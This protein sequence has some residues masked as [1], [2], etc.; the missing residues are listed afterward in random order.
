MAVMDLVI[1]DLDTMDLDTTM[2]ISTL[3]GV[4]GDLVVEVPLT[5]SGE[6]IVDAA[7]VE[8]VLAGEVVLERKLGRLPAHLSQW[9]QVLIALSNSSSNSNSNSSGSL[10]VRKTWRNERVFSMELVK[11]CPVF[12]SLLV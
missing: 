8:E 6:A 7:G 1:M 10:D 9:R 2:V 11:L 3:G 12:W 4:L 5:V